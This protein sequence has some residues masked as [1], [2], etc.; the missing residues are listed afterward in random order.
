MSNKDAVL[1]MRNAMFTVGDGMTFDAFMQ[2]SIMAQAKIAVEMAD[3]P[4]QA[5]EL[6]ARYYE[7]A[8]TAIPAYWP[9]KSRRTAP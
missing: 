7:M 9:D 2:G 8:L 3:S 1:A 5:E 4:E 6:L